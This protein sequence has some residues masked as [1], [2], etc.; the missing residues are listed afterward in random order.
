M[1]LLRFAARTMLA[2]YFVSSGVNA[3]RDPAALAP[4][5]EPL[6]DRV[7]PV[8]K[9]YAPDQVSDSIPDDPVTVVRINGVLQLVGGLALATGKGR[10]LGALILAATIIPATIAKHPFWTRESE[11]ERDAD[12]SHFLKNIS[13]LGGVLL[14][15]RD[16][17]GRPSIAYRAQKGG[18]LLARDTKKASQ[19]I[20]DQSSDLVEGA[21]ASGA[22]IAATVAA[23][24][25]KAKKHAAKQLAE[26]KK[27]AAIAVKQAQKDA[28]QAEKERQK[29]ARK[30]LV[31]ATKAAR[32]AEKRADKNIKRGEN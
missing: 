13:L 31:V 10:R 12:R 17:E 27:A 3:L 16:T 4:V 20:A 22:A 11:E 9:Q 21:L 25:R 26:G 29:Q 5:A 23:T 6:I 24:S 30:D 19:K 8:L 7:V 28:Q 15:S 2:S 14:A 1:T 18:Q 32:K